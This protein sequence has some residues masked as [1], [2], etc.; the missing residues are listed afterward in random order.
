[1]TYDGGPMRIS[2]FRGH[3][4]R[5]SRQ[6]H[7]SNFID[8]I[9]AF[10]NL[11][12]SLSIRLVFW[13]GGRSFQLLLKNIPIASLFTSIWLLCRSKMG[14]V[15]NSSYIQFDM[16]PHTIQHRI[17]V[18]ILVLFA[19]NWRRLLNV[20]RGESFRMPTNTYG[21]YVIFDRRTSV[22]NRSAICQSP[23]NG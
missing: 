18:S 10:P 1:M 6:I 23:K 9:C 14:N 22:G 4:E 2:V 7:L 21:I 16:L 17:G 19:S 5:L 11:F 13:F 20:W 8:F 3:L 12:G 15:R